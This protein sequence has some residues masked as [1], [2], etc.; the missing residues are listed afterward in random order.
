[1][2]H[3]RLPFLVLLCLAFAFGL[4]SCA[5]APP[6]PVGAPPA[7]VLEPVVEPVMTPVTIAGQPVLVGTVLSVTDG[8]T[9]KV[10][11]GSGPITVRFDAID[12]PEKS[13][14]WGREAYAELARRLNRQVVALDVRTQDR[15][16]RLVAVVYLGDEN[17]NGWMVQQGHAWAYRQY[18]NEADY[19]TWEA[20]ARS[21]RLGLWSLAASSWQA[22]WEWRR[23][24]RG[25]G[26][27][28]TEYRHETAEHCRASMR[29]A[30][31]VFNDHPTVAPVAGPNR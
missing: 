6:P 27:A 11:L 25:D 18:L 17:I 24:Q 12:A 23:V 22:P 28:F 29:R 8:D 16:D 15:Y 19:C 14:P 26:G 13:Q 1:M 4:A 30:R 31:Q 5:T 3:T 21:Q 7:P 20:S 9:I 10:Q 2:G